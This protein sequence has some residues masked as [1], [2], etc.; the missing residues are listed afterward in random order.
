VAPGRR[1]AYLA[2]MR[3]FNLRN[4]SPVDGIGSFIEYWKQPTPYRWQILLV[5]VALTF[6]MIV[7][8][9]PKTERAPPEKM[10]VTWIN[11]WPEGR[12]EAE[13]VASNI[14]N[15]KKKDEAAALEKQREQFRKEFYRKLA[16]ASGLDPDELEREYSRQTPAAPAKPAADAPAPQ[17]AGS[18][19]K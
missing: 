4:V 13:I 17:P 12:S 14:A 11:S 15:Q 9:A 10:Q 3:M 18:P 8:F 2:P 16:K 19:T 5:S 1:E 7:L 6:T